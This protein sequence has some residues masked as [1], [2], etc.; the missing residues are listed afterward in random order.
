M[1]NDSLPP[2]LHLLTL[3]RVLIMLNNGNKLYPSVLLSVLCEK[4]GPFINP[5]VGIL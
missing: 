4:T 1:I 2:H 5:E 3:M